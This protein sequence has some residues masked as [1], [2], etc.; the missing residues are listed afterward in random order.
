MSEQIKNDKEN[1]FT[2]INTAVKSGNVTEG[3]GVTINQQLIQSKKLFVDKIDSC[4]AETVGSQY[5]S[6]FCSVHDVYSTAGKHNCLGCNF[7]DLM[8]QISDFLESSAQR[9]FE[10]SRIHHFYSMYFF[11]LNGVWERIVD[12]FDLIGIPN[13]Y[14]NS[15]FYKFVEIRRWTNFFKHPGVFNYLVHHPAYT[16]DGSDDHENHKYRERLEFPEAHAPA[17]SVDTKFVLDHYGASDKEGN[18]EQSNNKPQ[19]GKSN[20]KKRFDNHATSTVV[21]LPDLVALTTSACEGFELFVKL[22]K[23]N[24]V[25]VEILSDESTVVQ[26]FDA[27]YETPSAKQ[28]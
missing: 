18:K 24:P 25:Y 21:V 12:I 26:Y 15:H 7:D 22:I 10:P 8:W 23:E 11:L 6:L 2:S 14:R 13:S 20:P 3:L 27:E 16:I 9:E 17:L 1:I 19:G 5:T 28:K 4:Y